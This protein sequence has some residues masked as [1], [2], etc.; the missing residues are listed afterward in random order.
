MKRPT[1]SLLLATTLALAAVAPA[2]AR[3]FVLVDV[4]PGSWTLIDPEG[5][6]TT[7]GGVVR[8]VWSVQVLKN[9]LSK[10][11]EQP[12]YVRT[13]TD[14]DCDRREFRWREFSAFSRSGDNLVTKQNP[15]YNWDSV[16]KAA[17][18]LAGYQVACGKSMGRGI[19]AAESVAKLVIT[20]MASWDP[21]PPKPA[22]KAVPAAKSAPAKAEPKRQ[23]STRD[24]WP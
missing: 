20:I 11:P 18:T 24:L 5:V 4:T 13:L 10:P 8:R 3:N 19:I 17:D 16:D 21:P 6:E 12:G 2:A 22:A 14:Y 15:N 7:G 23:L 9:I 1:A